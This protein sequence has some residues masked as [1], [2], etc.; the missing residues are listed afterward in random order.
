MHIENLY[1]NPDIFMFKEV[2][3][4]EKL[5][6][7]SSHVSWK[8]EDLKFFAGGEKH[9]KFISIFDV[10]NLAD[11]FRILGHNDVKVFGEAYGG[12]CM[13]MKATYGDKLKFCAFDVKINDCWLSVPK[14]E[15]VVKQLNLEFVHY[16]KCSTN[17]DDLNRERDAA[18]MQAK[19]NGI[20]EDKIR[21]GIVIRPLIELTKNDG[22]RIIVKHKRDEFMETKTPREVD[23]TKIKI[24][25]EAQTIA[26]EWVVPMRLEHVLQKFIDPRMEHT[27]DIIR[28]MIQDIKRESSG[29]VVWN[30]DVDRAIGHQTVK[31][32]KQRIK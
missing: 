11:R 16:V 22:S 6:G 29:E 3:C 17:L 31:L 26:E 2:F 28:E 5:H 12:K 32:F 18:S 24:L 20:V 27:G 4:L 8:D 14:A 23:P 13:S 30:K 9:E 19:R 1:K 15:D 21:E 10:A 7:T 25:Q